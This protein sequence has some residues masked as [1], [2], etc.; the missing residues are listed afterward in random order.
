MFTRR[1]EHAIYW[2]ENHASGYIGRAS[3]VNGGSLETGEL[4]SAQAFR[5]LDRL[6]ANNQIR[7]T[8]Y[9]G[10]MPKKAPK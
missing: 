3:G 6:A 5:E 8:D 2:L 7:L 4:S 1:L 10:V 9:L